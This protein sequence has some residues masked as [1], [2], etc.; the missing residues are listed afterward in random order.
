MADI[1]LKTKLDTQELDEAIEKATRL[2]ELLREAQRLANV[3]IY[4]KIGISEEV[5]RVGSFLSWVL[6]LASIFMCW[7]PSPAPIFLPLAEACIAECGP[8][9]CPE[10]LAAKAAGGA[11]PL[12]GAKYTTSILLRPWPCGWGWF[13]IFWT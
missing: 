10:Q 5:Q 4:L 7:L 2:V 11:T 12:P 6:V 8:R 3:T 9:T 13:F 1:T